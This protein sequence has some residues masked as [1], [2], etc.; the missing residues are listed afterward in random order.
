M[1]VLVPTAAAGG[2]CY[3]P[4]DAEMTT[5]SKPLVGIGQCSFVDTVVYIEPGEEVR[6]V[7]KDPVPHT[8]TGAANSWGTERYLDQGDDVSYTF[9]KDGVY[10]YYCLLHPSMVGAVV[11]GDAT[12][13]AALTDG[14]AAVADTS[15]LAAAETATEPVKTT[16]MR[17]TAAIAAAGLVLIVLAVLIAR[18]V[19]LRRRAPSATPAP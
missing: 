10:P 2:G 19:T 14:A 16:G 7:N 3:A 15:E 12:K 9:E 17:T 11:V 8:V 5:G 18:T 4:T 13:A 6:W 1:V